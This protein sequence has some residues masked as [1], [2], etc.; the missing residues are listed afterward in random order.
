MVVADFRLKLSY[1]IFIGSKLSGELVR[2]FDGL[3]VV[4]LG[5]NGCSAK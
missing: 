4:C 5:T 2:C 3:L 1:A